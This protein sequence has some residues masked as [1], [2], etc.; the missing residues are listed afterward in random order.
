MNK[1]GQNAND[2]QKGFELLTK[3]SESK[4]PCPEAFAELA[5]VYAHGKFSYDG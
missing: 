2:F 5:Y 1:N 4:N 3:I